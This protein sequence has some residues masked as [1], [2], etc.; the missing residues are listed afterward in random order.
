MIK[1]DKHLGIFT[2]LSQPNK[3]FLQIE[4]QKSMIETFI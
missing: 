3:T 1:K 4:F 2:Y